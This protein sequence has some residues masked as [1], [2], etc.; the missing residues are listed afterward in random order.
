MH[1]RLVIGKADLSIFRGP[2]EK[3]MR[4]STGLL[5]CILASLKDVDVNESFYWM[6]SVANFLGIDGVLGDTEGHVYAVQATIASTHTSPEKGIKKV[7][8]QFR[9]EVLPVCC[10]MKLLISDFSDDIAD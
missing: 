9:P 7:W 3:S 5:R 10:S 1:K 4:P 8:N 2:Q 6:P